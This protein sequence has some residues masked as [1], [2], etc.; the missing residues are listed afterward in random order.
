MT[1]QTLEILGDEWIEQSLVE[2]EYPE[3]IASENSTALKNSLA[4]ED[5]LP[6]EGSLASE[7]FLPLEYSLTSV[8]SPGVENSL[9]SENSLASG[10]PIFFQGIEVDS[11]T[12]VPN[13]PTANAKVSRTRQPTALLNPQ[14]QID[15]FSYTNQARVT[16]TVTVQL[17]PLVKFYI[18]EDLVD[19]TLQSSVW[20]MDYGFWRGG[21]NDYLFNFSDQLIT[22]DGTYTFSTFV[23]RSVLDEDTGFFQGGPTDEIAAKFNLVSSDPSLP[24][25]LEA[26]T[27]TITGRF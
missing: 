5:S 27:N 20:G 26:W 9:D 15:L 11:L 25:N 18:E 23:D 16:A 3:L 24:V 7:D 22:R 2:S 6:L 1:Q 8:Y 4:S 19:V 13:D 10:N 17:S 12:G 14:L 21:D